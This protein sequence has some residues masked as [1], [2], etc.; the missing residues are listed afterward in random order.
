MDGIECWD[1]DYAVQI[2]SGENKDSPLLAKYCENKLPP[3][4]TS[5]GNALH[6]EVNYPQINFVAKYS[7]LDTGTYFLY[8]IF[9]ILLI[10]MMHDSMWWCTGWCNWIFRIS[11]ISKYLSS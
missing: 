10:Y 9:K 5:E 2:Y 1:E 3:T 7:T 11:S 4:L 8:V 6:I